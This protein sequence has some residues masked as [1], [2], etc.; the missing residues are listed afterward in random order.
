MS[1]QFVIPLRVAGLVKADF[2]FRLYRNGSRIAGAEAAIAVADTG[3]DDYLVT[4]LPDGDRGT[5]YTLTWRYP[6]GAFYAYTWPA[7]DGTPPAIVI[8]QRDAGL[9]AADFDLVLY[10]NGVAQAIDLAVAALAAGD[11]H[12]SGWPTAAEGDRWLLTWQLAGVTFSV[13]W[14]GAAAAVTTLP[15]SAR[16]LRTRRMV[17]RVVR[18]LGERQTVTLR[19]RHSLVDGSDGPPATLSLVGAHPAGA[20]AVT[21][22]ASQLDG[23]LPPGLRLTIGGVLYTV[24]GETRAK[25]NAL[26]DVPLAAA[27]AA[28]AADNAVVTVEA[29]R[30][31]TFHAQASRRGERFGDGTDRAGAEAL[32]LA[33]DHAPAVP[34][35]D[36]LLIVA[37][38][39]RALIAVDPIRPGGTTAGWRIQTEGRA[40]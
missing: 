16:G 13:A 2:A 19:R 7:Q 25:S 22:D 26:A 38:E 37:G 23:T 27:L 14:T 5:W 33:A 35:A 30:D 15:A 18:H 21:L 4:G 8:P 20:T 31:F 6:D 28:D 11:Y 12:V 39:A 10:R 24:A 29:Y 3:G 1:H 32:L 40:A 9:V 17:S 34:R 36:D